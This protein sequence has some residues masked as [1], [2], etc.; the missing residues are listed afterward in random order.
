M[1]A[2][3]II[4]NGLIALAGFYLAWRLWR[5]GKTL[6]NLADA[7]SDWERSTH[8]TLD[9]ALTPDLMLQGQRGAAQLR[10]YYGALQQLHRQGQQMLGV[11]NTLLVL[12]RWLVVPRRRRRG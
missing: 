1:I 6:A 12:N 2:T 8:S 3:V 10:H 5:L 7:L 9:P 4:L 11:V